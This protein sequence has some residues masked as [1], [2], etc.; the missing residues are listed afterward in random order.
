M[1]R[2]ELLIGYGVAGVLA[3]NVSNA[4]WHD[5]FWT[6]HGSW[7]TLKNV[8]IGP[9]IG[10]VSF[11]CSIGN[12]PLAAALWRGGISFGGVISFLFADLITLPLLLIYRRYYGMRMMLRMLAAF[13]FCMSVAALVTE[14][15]F[16]VAGAVPVK[17]PVVIAASHFAWNYTTSLNFIFVPI[18]GLL[19]WLYRSRNH[20]DT[21]GEYARDPVCGMQVVA[22]EAPAAI[23]H[24]GMQW[25]FCSEHCAHRFTEDPDRFAGR[26]P[27]VPMD[28]PSERIQNAAT[29]GQHDVFQTHGD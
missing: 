17:R 18:F 27:T 4:V 22:G 12:V 5:L 14:S 11:V 6:G 24:D 21:A 15:L 7:T 28:V 13:W 29:V 9:F 26:L 23:A 8:V 2:K 3:V 19:F 25:F 20:G 10:I 1:L 16:R